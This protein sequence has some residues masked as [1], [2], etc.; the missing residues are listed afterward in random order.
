MNL[1]APPA[2]VAFVVKLETFVIN[3]LIA[4]I[5]A[6]ALVVFL[7][8][9]I[10]FLFAYNIDEEKRSNGKRHMLWGI[11]GIFIMVAINA[12]IALIIRT[13]TP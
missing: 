5:F 3:P 2:V 10:E 7:W 4:V 1:S 12:I 6:A 13:V 8:G 11:I 9:L